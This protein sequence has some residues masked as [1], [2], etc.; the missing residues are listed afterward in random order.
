[1]KKKL[2]TMAVAAAMAAPAAA[3]AEAIIY[4][5]LH[6]S[7]DYAD[8]TNAYQTPV[9]APDG[10][11]VVDGVDFNGWGV[12]GQGSYM[13]GQS[14]AQR[15]GVKGSE[16]IG[17]GLKAI[18]QFEMGF[19]MGASDDNIPGGNNNSFSVR[20]SFVGLAGSFGSVL[21]GR[22]DT[23]LKI[24]TGKLDMFAD[25]MADYNGTVGFNGL[26]VDNAIA[27]ISPSFSG[28]QFMGA[29][30][31]PGGATAFGDDNVNSDQLNGAYSL[32]GIYSN[33]PYYASI[34]YESLSNEMFMDSATSRA[35]TTVAPPPTD[36]LTP[37]GV[38]GPT[39]TC[40]YVDNDYAKWRFGLGIL[41]WNG[42]TFSF[43][44]E[45]QDNNPAGG[46]YDSTVRNP[47]TGAFVAVPNGIKSQELWQIQA[48]YA[49]GNNQVK[50][51]YGQAGRDYDLST[52][53]YPG[54]GNT[55]NR[56][57]IEDWDGDRSTWAIAFDHNFS[58][59][60]KAY[61][62]YTQVDD[63]YEDYT[64]MMGNP[65]ITDGYTSSWD[66]FSVG[67]IHSF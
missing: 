20:N 32:A 38:L 67:M 64:T 17:N 61:V 57:M 34:A 35:G 27:Y 16:D 50:A 44:Y 31:A 52:S 6:V 56:T 55:N 8:V 30:V 49:F 14:R 24:S 25:T 41:D 2:I 12:N 5:K 40:G 46:T 59:R 9:F 21:V 10:R 23:P 33:G 29:L 62:L 22:H 19:A 63:D 65:N 58:K 13:P 28:F 66:G 51:M 3:M 39:S 43:V 47:Q 37:T 18:Y 4:G 11:K 42:F 36:C 15:V 53:N 7:I 45:N 60:T 26:R 54:V 48:G 1:M